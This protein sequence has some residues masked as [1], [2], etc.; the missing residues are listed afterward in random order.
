MSIHWPYIS[1]ALRKKSKDSRVRRIPKRIR[2]TGLC[3]VYIEASLRV[4]ISTATISA[5]TNKA[6]QNRPS[7][8]H[9]QIQNPYTHKTNICRT[10][11]H[12]GHAQAR[13]AGAGA[14]TADATSASTSVDNLTIATKELVPETQVAR[15]SKTNKT[16]WND[17][18]LP[19]CIPTIS[20]QPHP[21]TASRPRLACLQLD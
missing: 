12:D 2:S 6:Q 9:A 21:P 15:A 17:K 19:L 1:T 3:T 18:H 13:A 20:T 8:F 5:A 16:M 11:F 10:P 7:R 4:R 14:A